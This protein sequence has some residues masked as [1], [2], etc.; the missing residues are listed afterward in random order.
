[1]RKNKHSLFTILVM[2]A[3]IL[4]ISYMAVC[5]PGQILTY[6]GVISED[7][8]SYNKIVP[9]KDYDS[10]YN[11]DPFGYYGSYDDQDP[12]GDYYSDNDNYPFGDYDSYYD[13][14]PYENNSYNNSIF[15]PFGINSFWDD[16]DA[17]PHGSAGEIDGT[18]IVVSIFA[19]DPYSD[20]DEKR[21][22]ETI[23]NINKYLSIAGDYL[24]DVVSDYG[25]SATFITDFKSNPDLRYEMNFEDQLTDPDYL[26]Y[27]DIDYDVWEYI[28][29]NIDQ[30]QLMTEFHA[31]NVV[32]MV[33]I[34][35]DE[36]NEAITC[37]RNWYEGMPYEYEIV[38]LYNIDYEVV[39]CPAVYAHEILHTFGAPDL[40]TESEDFH[41]D[42]DFLSYVEENMYNDLMLTCTDLHSYDYNYKKVTNEVGE[43]TAYYV[44]LI[45]H[46]DIVEEWRLRASEHLG[47]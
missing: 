7:T 33:M 42:E 46:S 31:D 6:S 15:D 26:D 11:C 3:A 32:Y 21:D 43:V 38:Y 19:E 47:Y 40:Y 44:G 30:E 25:K 22:A 4:R 34:N 10:Y 12:C 2:T 23:T 16:H 37:T 1:M 17:F 36:S 45:D 9:F 5:L 35:S 14:D 24:E 8:E 29:D 27:G 39:N 18:T 20:W 41:I 13:Q 28:Y